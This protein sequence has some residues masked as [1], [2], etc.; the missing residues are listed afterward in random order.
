MG[1]HQ[2]TTTIKIILNTKEVHIQLMVAGVITCMAALM[3]KNNRIMLMETQDRDR[4]YMQVVEKDVAAVVRLY[5][6]K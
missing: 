4:Q 5:E 6:F 1:F 3:Y 2:I